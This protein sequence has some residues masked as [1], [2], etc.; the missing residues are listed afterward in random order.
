MHHDAIREYTRIIVIRC[1]G[2]SSNIY[3]FVTSNGKPTEPGGKD[4]LP[5]DCC[6]LGLGS[7]EDLNRIHASK[8]SRGKYYW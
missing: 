3:F 2:G 6:L 4:E 7:T 1:T 8:T 5:C